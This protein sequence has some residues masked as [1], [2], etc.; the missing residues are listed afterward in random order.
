[1]RVREAL[2]VRWQDVDFDQATLHVHCQ[3]AVDDRTIV[4]HPKTDAGVRDLPILPALRRRLLAHRLAS[5]WKGPGDFV[6]A[7]ASGTPK[8]YPCARP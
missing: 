3:L 6:C 2:A 7:T 5:I 8:G 1:M 4:P